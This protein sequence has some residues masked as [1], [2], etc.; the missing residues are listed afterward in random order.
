MTAT[1]PDRLR[2]RRRRHHDEQPAGQRPGLRDPARHRR[3]PGAGAERCGGQAIVITGAGGLLRR[4]RHPRVRLAQGLAEPNLLSVILALE[5]RASPVVA[6]IHSVAMG[7]G[8]ELAL[9]CH[10]RVASPG[11]TRSPAEVKI[12]LIP[13]AGGTQ[14]LPRVLG[15]D[16]LNMIVSGDRS[17][18]SC[19]PAAGQKLFDKIDGD[20][21]AGAV[22]FARKEVAD[23]RPLPL[24]RNMKVEHPDGRRLPSSS[25]A[26]WWA[27]GEELPRRRA[28][29]R[30]AEVAAKLKFDAGMRTSARSSPALM[31]T[32]ECKAA[33][34]LRPSAPPPRSPTCPGR[35]RRARSQGGRDRRRHHGRRH[36]DELPQ[37]RRPGDHPR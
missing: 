36:L 8:L 33:L 37:R 25:P 24:V 3:R 1:C 9:G 4:R 35:R 30:D 28:G 27:D 23:K 16:A 6:A 15:G 19:W 26:T 18:A 5:A 11:R 22:A 17:R 29:A 12:G 7:G 21:I 31:F 20:L 14:R 34:R 32:P 13:G 10:Y 2:R